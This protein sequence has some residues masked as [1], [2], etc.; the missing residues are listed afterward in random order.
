M[1]EK[2]KGSGLSFAGQAIYIGIDMHLR[3]WTICVRS[4]RLELG[5]PVTI[6]PS[7]ES[8]YG[9]LRRHYP[10]GRYYAVYEAGYFGFSHARELEVL[11]IETLVVNPSDIPGKQKERV[12][13][14]DRS[15][16]R[17]LSRTMENGELRGIYIPEL[18]A[19]ECRYLSRYRSQLVREQ[20]RLKNHIKSMLRQFG[21]RIPEEFQGKMYW[22]GNFIKWMRTVRFRTPYAQKAYEDM[23]DRMEEGRKRQVKVL[24]EMKEMVEENPRMEGIVKAVCTVPGIG[25][26]S[27]VLLV[28]EIIDMARF[29][30]LEELASYVGLSPAIR[31]SDEKE[32]RSGITERHHQGLRPM[33]IEAAWIAVRKD[34]ALTMKFGELCKR[35][36]RNKAI[37]R[38]ARMLLNRIRSVWRSQ[39]PYAYSVIN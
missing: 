31:S 18:E 23:L 34:P 37:I 24:R 17:K 16:S 10:E 36:P 8:L 9:Y 12:V 14:D 29:R 27:A 15:D 11:G 13:K 28:T 1:E 33:L 3:Q 7:A 38:I 21:Y 32:Y 6:D 2:P 19:E 20:V 4:N 26:R 5:K 35:M 30:R 22:S 25:F 39:N